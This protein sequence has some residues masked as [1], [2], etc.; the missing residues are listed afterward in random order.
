MRL[1]FVD[2]DSSDGP[3]L[4]SVPDLILAILLYSSNFIDSGNKKPRRERFSWDQAEM[5]PISEQSIVYSE[6]NQAI[7]QTR[8]L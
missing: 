3:V 7:L 6:L 2:N 5:I 8:F 1:G 4:P